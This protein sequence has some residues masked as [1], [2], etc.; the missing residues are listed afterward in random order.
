[1]IAD[2]FGV[3]TDQVVGP[4]WLG[5]ERYDIAANIPEGATK[6]QFHAMLGN[7]LRERFGLRFHLE[8][9]LRPIFELRVG[10]NGP[11]LEPARRAADSSVVSPQGFGETD[12]RGCLNPPS[13]FEGIVARPAPGEMCLTARN[14]AVG[15]LAKALEQPAGRP[16]VDKTGL[17]GRYDLKVYFEHYRPSDAGATVGPAPSV[18]TAVREQLGLT[19]ESGQA[20]FDQLIIDSIDR[21][22]TPN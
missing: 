6:E 4:A 10:K 22:P 5:T 20:A 3:R 13:S 16:I 14:V 9:A 7:L 11:R 1:L 15:D 12:A 17:T 19:L 21:E 8:S 18:F 2:A